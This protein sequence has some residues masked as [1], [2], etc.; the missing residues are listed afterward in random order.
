MSPL[1]SRLFSSS[2]T[3]L[4][5]QVQP[6]NKAPSA[7]YNPLSA[8]SMVPKPSN[9]TQQQQQQQGYPPMFSM[10]S[11]TSAMASVEQQLFAN[12]STIKQLKQSDS[13]VIIICLDNV[14]FTCGHDS[15]YMDMGVCVC[16]LMDICVNLFNF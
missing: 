3:F 9:T 10:S 1:H 6:S 7:A 14:T 12:M 4:A 11:L 5:A 15:L 16:I 13:Q 8:P 2:S